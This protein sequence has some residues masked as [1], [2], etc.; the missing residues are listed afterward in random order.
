MKVFLGL[1]KTVDDKWE[2]RP[3]YFDEPDGIA[4]RLGDGSTVV[5]VAD[6]RVMWF[7]ADG[8]GVKA[9]RWLARSGETADMP[10]DMP[11]SM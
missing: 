10:T 5:V 8:N 7:D 11:A 4:C 3:D 2:P 6:G 9:A 1:H